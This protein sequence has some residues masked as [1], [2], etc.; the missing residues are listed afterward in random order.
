M[1]LK[2]EAE[3]LKLK[4]RAN[5][6]VLHNGKVLVCSINDNGFWCCPGGHIHLGEDSKTAVIREAYEEVGIKFE[7]AKPLMVMESFFEGKKE[8]RFHEIG[9]YYLM[10][11]EVPEEKLHDYSFDENDEGKMVHLQFKWVDINSLDSIDLRPADL[12]K[13]LMS[14]NYE[15]KHIIRIED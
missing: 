3:N 15:L 13:I 2:L 6:V 8:K 4:V 7:D 11:G 1:D 5:A 12:K 14:G 10:Q 9:F